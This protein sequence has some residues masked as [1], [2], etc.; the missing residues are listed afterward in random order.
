MSAEKSDKILTNKSQNNSAREDNDRHNMSILNEEV[1]QY[2]K[3]NNDQLAKLMK[4][5]NFKDE[6]NSKL[7]KELEFGAKEA[8]R[9]IYEIL[10]QD[11][12]LKEALNKET[13]NKLNYLYEKIISLEKVLESLKLQIETVMKNK[14][15]VTQTTGRR[16]ISSDRRSRTRTKSPVPVTKKKVEILSTRHDNQNIAKAYEISLRRGAIK[17]IPIKPEILNSQDKLKEKVEKCK[18]FFVIKETIDGDIC[19]VAR[20]IQ[21][22]SMD[23][24]LSRLNKFKKKFNA[25]RNQKFKKDEYIYEI[26][27]TNDQI[28]F[29]KHGCTNAMKNKLKTFFYKRKDTYIL[30]QSTNQKNFQKGNNQFK[31]GANNKNKI[32]GM[33]NKGNYNQKPN[34]NFRTTRNNNNNNNMNKQI[35]EKLDRMADAFSR[36]SSLRNFF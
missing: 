11:K 3:S 20:A 6:S 25:E 18:A 28:R 23:R 34:N 5:I 7:T 15:E 9:Q 27:M 22:F 17:A 33:K 35:L 13:D 12:N 10:D 31:N 8:V 1:Q 19:E 16:G 21:D 29:I 24:F 26:K 30:A 4:Y 14:K 32:V 36:A 2:I